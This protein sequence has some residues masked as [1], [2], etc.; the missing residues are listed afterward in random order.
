MSTAWLSGNSSASVW[1]GKDTER[2]AMGDSGCGGQAA[3]PG[4]AKR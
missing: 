3:E 1:A 2:G 4:T